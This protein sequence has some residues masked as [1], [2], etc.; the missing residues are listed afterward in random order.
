MPTGDV[1]ALRMKGQSM[2]RARLH[3]GDLALIRMQDT[4]EDGEIAALCVG[5][6][7]DEATIKRV[8]FVED[9]ITLLPQS[10]D[11][12]HQALTYRSDQVR[13]VG[14]VVGVWWG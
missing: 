1:I 10:D 13:V 7:L 6:N 4:I 5:E 11:P 14:K 12:Q 9:Y 2:E 3:D 8:H